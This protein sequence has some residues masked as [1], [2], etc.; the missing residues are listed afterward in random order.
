MLAATAC[1]GVKTVTNL[2]CQDLRPSSPAT[3]PLSQLLLS[4]NFD[5]VSILSLSLSVCPSVPPFLH[6]NT[7]HARTHAR[8]HTHTHT[9]S[10][11]Y[12]K[13]HNLHRMVFE[14]YCVSM[15]IVAKD[16]MLR[17]LSEVIAKRFVF[18]FFAGG[19]YGGMFD[20]I[21]I[22]WTEK[23]HNWWTEKW[24]NWCRNVD[25][26]YPKNNLTLALPSNPTQVTSLLRIFHSSKI[27]LYP[28]QSV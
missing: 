6:T 18:G 19:G 5:V 28:Y 8:T 27:I 25:E 14:D 17:L 15:G 9:H 2:S 1:V 23:W 7:L 13:D 16:R 24:H 26:P 11:H 10:G 12:I 22:V 3:S 4:L 20:K 21:V